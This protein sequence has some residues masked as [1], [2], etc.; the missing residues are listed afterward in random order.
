MA[1]AA[2][3]LPASQ[4]Y[5]EASTSEAAPAFLVYLSRV[6]DFNNKVESVSQ[7]LE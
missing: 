6:K 5:L 2:G 1:V 4:V 3:R 7:V